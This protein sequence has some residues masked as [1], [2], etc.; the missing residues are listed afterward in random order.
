M[1][2]PYR[3]LPNTY[4]NDSIEDALTVLMSPHGTDETLLRLY[5][6]TPKLNRDDPRR[7]AT[8]AS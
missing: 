6:Y 8:S 3:W 4:S 1:T 2:D 5:G 7:V